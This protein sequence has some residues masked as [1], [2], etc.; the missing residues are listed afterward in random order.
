MNIEVGSCKYAQLTSRKLEYAE[1]H[2]IRAQIA[3]QHGTSAVP[4]TVVYPDRASSVEGSDA[5]SVDQTK[6]LLI[7]LTDSAA[8]GCQ[9]ATKCL[10]QELDL[11]SD[12]ASEKIVSSFSYDLL[13]SASCAGEDVIPVHNAPEDR[14]GTPISFMG[15]AAL[16]ITPLLAPASFANSSSL[17]PNVLAGSPEFPSE[18]STLN[19]NLLVDVDVGIPPAPAAESEA[20]VVAFRGT[21][22]YPD[23]ISIPVRFVWCD[24]PHAIYF[25][26]YE[27]RTQFDKLQIKLR[28]CLEGTKPIPIR[29]KN[30]IEVGFKCAVYCDFDW[31]RAEVVDVE[32]FP[33]C[34]VL[35]VDKGYKRKVDLGD[36]YRLPPDLECYPRM[37]L[38]CSLFG[39]YPPSGSTWDRDV[40][41]W[42]VCLVAEVTKMMRFKRHVVFT[43]YT[44]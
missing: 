21:Q 14:S 8:L 3:A 17:I 26:T 41:A 44:G 29:K 1:H 32:Q 18:M 4:S 36:I 28:N 30:K 35:L 9:I 11:T 6:Q 42:Y 23:E 19:E 2:R 12:S 25:R 13:D 33:D 20:V 34:S 38:C 37:I 27:Q 39:V 43:L 15:N 5:T 22:P 31:W 7:D 40:S 24:S 10:R 16:S